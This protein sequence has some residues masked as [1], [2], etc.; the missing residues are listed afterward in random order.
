M[1]DPD[2]QA[3]LD[4]AVVSGGVPLVRDTVA[5]T[6]AHYR[7]LALARQGPGYVPEEVAQ[8]RDGTVAGPDGPVPV[9]V[10]T[11]L[12]DRGRVL[13]YLHGGGFV[14]GDL[15]THDAV[16]RRVANAVGT[17]VASVD[18]R[19]G[20][21]HRHPAAVRD[22]LAV[23][24]WAA[25]AYP[26]RVR[27]VGGDSAGASLAALASLAARGTAAAPAAQ[28]LLY[29]ATDPSMTQA[30]VR[31]NAEGYFL[32]GREMAWFWG[33]YVSGGPDDATL[34]LLGADVAGA[35]AAVVATAEFDPLRD[36]GDAYARVLAA[37]GVPVRHLPGPGLIHGYFAFLGAAAAA[38]EQSAAVLA[39]FDELL[40][41]VPAAGR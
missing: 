29:P 18:Y 35:P 37:A 32:T 16:C 20:P 17:V 4:A 13:V 33:H 41:S 6:R 36:E 21:E 34:D 5:D 11:P 28:L 25:A 27:A 31:E 22:A 3:L 8:V 40:V 39:A 19:L 24:A 30:S 7:R 2:V 26:D 12:Q 38:D 10:Y 15:D 1:I 14:I 9:R 23:L